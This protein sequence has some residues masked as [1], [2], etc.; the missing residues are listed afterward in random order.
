MKTILGL[1]TAGTNIVNQLSKYKMYRPYVI[2]TENERTTKYKFRLPELSGPEE[3]ENMDTTKLEKWVSSIQ[4]RCTVFVCGGSNSSGLTL[5]A[6]EILHKNDIKIEV[7][8]FMPEIEVFSEEKTLQERL[9]RGVLQNY[10]RSGLFEKIC[11]VSNLKL[12]ELAG[13]TNVYDYYNQLNTVFTSTYYMLDVFK[14][15]KPITST[16]KSPKESCRITTIG[17]S[18]VEG[19]EVLFFPFNQEVD[20]VYYYGIHENKLKTEENLFRKITDKVKSKINEQRKVSFGIYP[21]QYEDDYIYTEYFSP[22][23]QEEVLDKD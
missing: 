17:L 14:N 19:D 18:S 1:G 10:A 11:L 21:T 16:F 2:S 7:V 8:Y 3:Y 9:C 22:K 4:D 15:T 6:L 5:K 12:E 13:S 23:I 20:V